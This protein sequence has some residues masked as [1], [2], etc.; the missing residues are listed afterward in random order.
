MLATSHDIIASPRRKFHRH[1]PR[2]TGSLED[3]GMPLPNSA[4]L[5]PFIATS[6]RFPATPS[7]ASFKN[8]CRSSQRLGGIEA[9]DKIVDRMLH[10]G[11]VGVHHESGTLKIRPEAAPLVEGADKVDM[12]PVE[13]VESR[14]SV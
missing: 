12:A 11:F 1:R 5:S 10:A 2:G 3:A 9:V 14:E 7:T 8:W 6:S 13:G 4:L